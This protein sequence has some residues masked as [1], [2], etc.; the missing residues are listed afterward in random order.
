MMKHNPLTYFTVQNTGWSNGV[1][2]FDMT[3]G[4]DT[5][6]FK[7]RD[8]ALTYIQDK[9]W[10]DDDVKW[11][12]LDHEVDRTYA[13]DDETKATHTVLY[14]YVDPHVRPEKM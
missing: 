13:G 12:I 11:R 2:W 3:N 9:H 4:R 7:T 10:G 8:E 1:S 14:E 5:I 6:R